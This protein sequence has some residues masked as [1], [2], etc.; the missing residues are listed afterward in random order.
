MSTYKSF[1]EAEVQSLL[2]E[3]E[4]PASIRGA[5]DKVAVIFT[6]DWCIDWVVM[7]R[8]LPEFAGQVEIYVLVYNQH[9]RFQE[10]MTFKEE[11]FG[12]FEI[13]YLRYFWKGQLITET[14][15]LPRNTFAALLTKEKPFSLK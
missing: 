10:I 6:Q 5:A 14:N 3:G 1:S 12:N 13:P 9:P 15:K 4:V 8:F 7:D 11:T 2:D